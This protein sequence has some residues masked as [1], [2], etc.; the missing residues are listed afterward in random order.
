MSARAR[1]LA[2][3]LGTTVLDVGLFALFSFLLV[4]PALLIARWFCGAIGAVANFTANRLW[5]F[6]DSGKKQQAGQQLGRYALVAV[7]AVSLATAIWWI[8]GRLTGGDPRLL[9]VI[10]MALVWLGFTFPLLRRW[11]FSASRRGARC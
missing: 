6:S 10:S 3:S 2:V 5:A 7:S 9:H 1:C 11:V 4:G 8:L